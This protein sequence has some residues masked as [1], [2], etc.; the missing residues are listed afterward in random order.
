M[1]T[2][3]NTSSNITTVEQDLKSVVYYGSVN[4]GDDIISFGGTKAEYIL[5]ERIEL[6]N[7][8]VANKLAIAHLLVNL[9]KDS[10][11]EYPDVNVGIIYEYNFHDGSSIEYNCLESEFIYEEHT[12]EKLYSAN[13][14]KDTLAWK[15]FD[16]VLLDADADDYA[17]ENNLLHAGID[18][19][20]KL[21]T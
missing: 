16:Q 13:V 1:K 10:D 9:D 17:K 14:N 8:E 2:N 21:T 12:E 18:A 3:K 11:G 20:N 5:N 15:Y 7:D 6:V 4:T 19:F